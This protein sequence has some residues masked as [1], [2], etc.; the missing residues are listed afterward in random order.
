MRPHSAILQIGVLRRL[1]QHN[2]DSTRPC[3]GCR[4]TA[5]AYPA[6]VAIC[7]QPPRQTAT[8]HAPCSACPA[9]SATRLLRGNGLSRPAGSQLMRCITYNSHVHFAHSTRPLLAGSSSWT[10]EQ[11]YVRL[12][13][14]TRHSSPLARSVHQSHADLQATPLHF[15]PVLFAGLRA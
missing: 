9:S 13:P 4:H 10:L 14:L 5:G 7:R 8:P 15:H 11:V 2:G 12:H 1:V 6:F 3:G